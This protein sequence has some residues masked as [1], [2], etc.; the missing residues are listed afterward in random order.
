MFLNCINSIMKFKKWLQMHEITDSQPIHKFDNKTRPRTNKL[1]FYQLPEPV[2][3]SVEKEIGY[4]EIKS[5]KKWGDSYFITTNSN[6]EIG[7]KPDGTHW[8]FENE[9]ED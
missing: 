4:E 7:Y 9:W 6:E 1:Y 8:N 3:L 5:I 2:Q